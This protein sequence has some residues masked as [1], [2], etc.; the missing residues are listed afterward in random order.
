[1]KA[2]RRRSGD[3]PDTLLVL[4]SGLGG[5]A[6]EVAE[7]VTVPFRDIPGLPAAGV[8][9]HAGTFV[10][11]VLEGRR[12]LLQAG[13]LHL[14]EGHP[15]EAVIGPVRLG[16]AL[17]AGTVLLTN[18]A[19]GIGR[20]LGPGSIMLLDDHINFTGRDPL[21]ASLP[22][23]ECSPSDLATPYDR[24][25]RERALEIA[26]RA[27]IPLHRG[28]YAAVLGPSYE[29]PAEIRFLEKAGATAVG[30]STVPEAVAARAL[31][32]R[33]LGLSL[34]T[35]RA[36][37]LGDGRLDH[38]AVIRVGSRSREL[39]ARVIRALLRELPS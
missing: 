29:T 21:G 20:G 11:G 3:P 12:V 31:G 1:M 36:A 6:E 33:V 39:M 19:G 34:I 13:R 22:G 18:A 32:L 23:T 26:A 15:M 9:G 8:D 27:G 4:G 37:G 2:F 7:A 17:G 25:Y 5:L 28:V 24:E 10:L 16:A 30:M 38:E 14:Y 35:N